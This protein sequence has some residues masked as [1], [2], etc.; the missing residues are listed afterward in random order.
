M[1]P[2]CEASQDP[3]TGSVCRRRDE[4]PKTRGR[5]EKNEVREEENKKTARRRPSVSHLETFPLVLTNPSA[6]V[7]GP[8]RERAK[9]RNPP[10]RKRSP[11]MNRDVNFRRYFAH[12]RLEAKTVAARNPATRDARRRSARTGSRLGLPFIVNKESGRGGW[13]ESER[14]SART[15]ARAS[16]NA[17]SSV[18]QK[19]PINEQGRQFPTIFC[20]RPVGGENG[21]GSESGHARCP[22][23]KRADREPPGSPS[24]SQGAS[25]TERSRVLDG[26][27]R[28]AC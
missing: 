16:E 4:E 24:D 28:G 13:D 26:S 23:A 18:P 27:K 15:L 12:V 19:I 9:M 20:S 22:T 7:R 17:E 10:S 21:G 5:K 25:N 14:K 1:R 2:R 11:S 8:L 6:R 3:T